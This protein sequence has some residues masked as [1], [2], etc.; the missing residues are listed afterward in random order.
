[1]IYDIGQTLDEK[2]RITDIHEG[3]MAL[4]YVLKGVFRERHRS[5]AFPFFGIH[6]R[7]LALRGYQGQP[8]DRAL[9][10]ARAIAAGMAAAPASR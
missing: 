9:S 2:F 5:D 4:I 10:I 7:R 1:M 8:I 3:G 6:G